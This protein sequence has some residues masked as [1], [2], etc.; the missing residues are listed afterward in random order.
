M[1]MLQC[2]SYRVKELSEFADVVD[3][4]AMEHLERRKMSGVYC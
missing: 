2:V 1:P 4:G 3:V